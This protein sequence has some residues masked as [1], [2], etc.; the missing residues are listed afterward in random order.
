MA[1]GAHLIC[2]AAAVEEGGRGVRF[3]VDWY[4]RAEPA[5]VVRFR[6]E[7]RAY[8]NRCAHVPVTLDWQ[9]GEFFDSEAR[10]LICGTHGA[11]YEPASGLCVLGPCKGRRLVAL[12][13]EERDG[14][15]FWLSGEIV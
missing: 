4:G 15:V 1:A 9:E 7:L 8:L 11:I 2:A 10:Y 14:Q 3:E 6:G 5:F 12:R 13:V